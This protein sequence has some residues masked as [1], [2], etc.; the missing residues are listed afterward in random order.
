MWRNAKFELERSMSNCRLKKEDE[1]EEVKQFV[2][3]SQ[4]RRID[5]NS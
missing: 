3:Q 1:Y 2:T 5:T 4:V